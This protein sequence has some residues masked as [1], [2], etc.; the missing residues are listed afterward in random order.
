VTLGYF[1]IGYRDGPIWFALIVAVGE[2]RLID[3]RAKYKRLPAMSERFIRH[4]DDD[5]PCAS[6]R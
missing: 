3:H 2:G 5:F 1:V 4:F 6:T